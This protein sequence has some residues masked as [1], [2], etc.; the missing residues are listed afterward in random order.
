MGLFAK[1]YI[2]LA[3]LNGRL[4]LI[5]ISP[6]EPDRKGS[7]NVKN[8]EPTSAL[9]AL[10]RKVFDTILHAYGVHTFNSCLQIPFRHIAELFK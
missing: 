9:A 1:T 7:K 6:N 3:T 8:G 4:I 5:R 10:I 2:E